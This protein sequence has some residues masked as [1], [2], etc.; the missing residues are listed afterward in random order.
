MQGYEK[1]QC[2]KRANVSQD[3]RVW[4]SEVGIEIMKLAREAEI[5][6]MNT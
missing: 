2:S 3:L 1:E 6:F 5:Q 4:G